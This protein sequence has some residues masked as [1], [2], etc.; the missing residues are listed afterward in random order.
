MWSMVSRRSWYLSLLSSKVSTPHTDHRDAVP[1]GSIAL[2]KLRIVLRPNGPL[3]SR[4]GLQFLPP[5]VLLL[6]RRDT[7]NVVHGQT[8]ELVVIFPCT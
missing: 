2:R 5:V 6:V 1:L 4:T 8:T 7:W 3:R